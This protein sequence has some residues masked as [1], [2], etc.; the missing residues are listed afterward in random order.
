MAK[1][2]KYSVNKDGHYLHAVH[3]GWHL[4]TLKVK[5]INFETGFFMR[6]FTPSTVDARL[7]LVEVNN[8]GEERILQ[9]P[10][11]NKEEPIW[12]DRAQWPV[13]LQRWVQ[14]WDA[15]EAA[16]VAAQQPQEPQKTKAQS[17]TEPPQAT[18]EK[19]KAN[20]NIDRINK[21][22]EDLPEEDNSSQLW[23][24]RVTDESGQEREFEFYGSRAMVK[25]A[26]KGENDVAFWLA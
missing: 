21:R 9:D 5:W 6:T 2:V 3:D 14:E 18:P 20:H 16:H 13:F 4:A 19:P 10:K 24:V 23:R 17:P 15:K 7:C 26:V 8:K 1:Y 11:G 22:R 25:D 12:K